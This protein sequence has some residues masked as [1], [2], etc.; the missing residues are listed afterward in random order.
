M[1]KR[2]LALGLVGLLFAM[3][4]VA[5]EGSIEANNPS[6]T[7]TSGDNSFIRV[8]YKDGYP[9]SGAG[10]QTFDGSIFIGI[11]DANGEVDCSFLSG[12]YTI[13]AY[14]PLGSFSQFGGDITCVFPYN[15]TITNDSEITPPTITILSPQNQTYDGRLV[16]LNFTVYDYSPI[17]WMGYSLDG[18]A[19]TT[20]TGNL[21]LNVDAGSHSVVVYAND[22]YGN[23]GSSGTVY[24]S[25]LGGYVV[26][27]VQYL[28]GYPRSGATVIEISP[29]PTGLGTSNES[30]YVE[31]HN[32]LKPGPYLVQA[33]YKGSQ[34][35]PNTGLYVNENGYGDTNIIANYEITPPNI[36][37]LSPQNSSYYVSVPLN[38]TLYDFSPISW[39]GYSLDGQANITVTGNT[40]LSGFQTFGSHSV[41]VYSNDTFGNMG[42]SATLCFTL[43]ANPITVQYLDGYPRSGADVSSISGPW[44][45]DIGTTDSNGQVSCDSLPPGPYTFRAIYRGPQFGQLTGGAVPDGAT[46]TANYEI[47][48]PNIT[49]LS[50]QNLTY[51]NS[52]VSLTFTFDD[53]DVYDLSEPATWMGYSLDG[54]AN[55]T[56]TDNTT[57]SVEDGLHGT[58]V[59][60]NDS[61]GNM[62]SSQTIYFS[63]DTVPPT[64]TVLSPQNTTYGYASV[65]LTFTVSEPA[66]WMGYNLDGQANV[67]ITDNTTLVGLSNGSHSI[68]VYAADAAGKMGSSAIISFVVDAAPSNCDGGKMPYLI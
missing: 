64:V 57:L 53:P 48:P 61:F 58:V 51:A 19:N 68:V 15:G 46:I 25:T 2:L 10:V 54:Q 39:I 63:V 56:I 49:I 45:G 13:R 12:A 24:F 32:V 44:R 29:S 33:T 50:P 8:Q 60:A 66:T 59:Y 38:F 5:T 42:S 18:Q 4:L 35:G 3:L 41:V 23:M 1:S 6:A 27:R 26:I 22:T 17:S 11:T 28:D 30:G 40:T 21:T 62:G 7:V 47:T 65:P 14:Y 9:R 20:V 43:H 67:T 34:F 37:I 52:S 55:I 31:I 36:T 16:P